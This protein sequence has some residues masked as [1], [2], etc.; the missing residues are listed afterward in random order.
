MR[1]KQATHPWSAVRR[2]FGK[3]FAGSTGD[4]PVPSGDSPDRTG[5]TVRANGHGLFTTLPAAV[6]VG[7]SPAGAGGSPAPPIFKTGSKRARAAFTLAEVLAALAF[8]AIVIPVA[9][10]GLRIANLAGQV[11]QRKAVAARISERVLNELMVTGQLRGTTQNGIVQEGAQQYQWSMRSE[12][13]PQDA[14]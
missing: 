12:P 2:V 11:G 14:M 10:E 8:M 7:G 3:R 5:A 4:S 13:W 6:P 1:F 9:V